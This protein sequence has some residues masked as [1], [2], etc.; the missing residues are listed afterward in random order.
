M[1]DR[2]ILVSNRLPV[3]I[4]AG[5]EGPELSASS[6]GL[7]T[8][9]RELHERGNGR[10][11]GWLGDQS[12]LSPEQ[13]QRFHEQA[14]EQRLKPVALT[15]SEVALYYDGY[16]NGVLWPLFHYLIEKVRL[17]S[18]NEWRAYV[19]VN[20][21]FADAVLEELEPG[22]TVWIHDYQLALVPAMVRRRAPSV[23]IGFFL[24]IPWPS[25][26]VFRIL[27]SRVDILTGLLGADLIGFHTES[28]RHNFIHAAAEVLGI[29]FG[30][31]SLT[32]EER[33]VRVGAFPIGIDIATFERESPEIDELKKQLLAETPGKKIVLGVDRLDYTKG[34]P[35]RL[36]AIDRLLEREPALRSQLHYIQLAVPTRE[37]VEEYGELRKMVNE[38]VGRINSQH[39]SPVS[40][41]V[42][43]LY[44]SVS[45]D[46]LLALYRAADVM[47]V[48]PLRDGMNLVAKE[49]VAARIDNRG[50]LVLSEFAG[51]ASELV[52]AINVNP[53]DITG[54]ALAVRHAMF[55]SEEEQ[56]VRMS[57]LRNIVKGQSVQ[58]WAE[59][60]LGELR[61]VQPSYFPYQSLPSDLEDVIVRVNRARHRTLLLDYD[62]TLAPIADLQSL[63]APD[64]RLL[65]LL[66]KL[67]G[68]PNT[69]IHVVTGRSQES[70]EPWLDGIPL[71]L[72]TEHGF[73]SRRPDGNWLPAAYPQPAFLEAAGRIMEKYAERTKGTFV[74]PKAASVAFHYRRANPYAAQE[75]LKSLK[76]ELAASLPPEAQLL[77][78]H[79]VLEVRMR[80]VDKSAAVHTALSHSPEDTAVLAAGDDRTDEDLF[81][82][83]PK[84]AVSVKVGPGP[85]AAQL[86]VETPSELQALLR[87]LAE[88]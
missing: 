14:L 67:A 25:S 80:G 1:S 17:D 33:T 23:R 5:P 85:T 45:P 7:A 16:S 62:G 81:A 19:Q 61:V 38:L 75:C 72:H 3:S 53:Y 48:T 37:K 32:W 51:A 52:A 13:A 11:I 78:G 88:A 47:L 26:D 73:R 41:P 70:I 66:L 18:S 49:Y 44:R 84:G 4:A 43:L 65:E 34:V 76:P 35:R 83:L 46:Q 71:W 29:D 63:A 60:F 22:D 2:V 55:M 54:I 69:D 28:Y 58:K 30:S 57:R 21:R 74:E 27:P 56:R 12:K 20:Q 9:L 40:S 79:K 15:A 87:R 82:A 50:A 59:T 39:G 24:H 64:P 42:Q 31:D 68:K 8:A 10:W 6:G 77:E 86:R 36:L